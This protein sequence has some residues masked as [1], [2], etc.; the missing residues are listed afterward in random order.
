MM[1][2]FIE[3]IYSAL[4]SNIVFV[5]CCWLLLYQSLSFNKIIGVFI[6]NCLKVLRWHR[7]TGIARGIAR[8]QM[9]GKLHQ[10]PKANTPISGGKFSYLTHIWESATLSR[11]LYFS[12]AAR[13]QKQLLVSTHPQLQN[14]VKFTLHRNWNCI[15]FSKKI[16]RWPRWHM[17]DVIHKQFF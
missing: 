1:W 11:K 3:Q 8:G 12:F 9:S 14:L 10:H 7:H 4:E 15:E 6:P 17:K 16:H 2:K 5:A 13:G